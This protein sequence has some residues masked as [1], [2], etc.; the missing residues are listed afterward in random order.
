[1]KEKNNNRPHQGKA[2]NVC[3]YIGLFIALFIF[4]TV[5]GYLTDLLVE[6]EKPSCSDALEYWWLDAAGALVATVII[7]FIHR[8]KNGDQK[9]D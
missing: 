9:P 2:K 4:F 5:I 8:R 1:M 7:Y 6:T 3:K